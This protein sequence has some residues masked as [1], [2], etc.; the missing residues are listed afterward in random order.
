MK[1]GFE[2]MKKSK[3]EDNKKLCEQIG[4][5]HMKL[6]ECKSAQE[7]EITRIDNLLKDLE[8]KF[9]LSLKRIEEDLH[10]EMEDEKK[11]VRNK[12]DQYEKNLNG[13]EK[14]WEQEKKEIIKQNENLKNIQNKF[15]NLEKEFKQEKINREE[16]EKDIKANINKNVKELNTKLENEKDNRNRN[17]KTLKDS[18]MNELDKRD[19]SFVDFQNKN[20]NDL[21]MLKEEV[22]A[23]L[24]NRF[25]HQNQIVSNISIFMKSFQE[26]LSIMGKDI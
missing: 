4:D 23:E 21:K 5:V 6:A 11:F 16:N 9:T 13:F 10:K 7:E 12:F 24:E 1:N 8:T 19:K 15:T 22:Y 17:I 18:F 14:K 26:A 25:D 20:T 2:E 3:E